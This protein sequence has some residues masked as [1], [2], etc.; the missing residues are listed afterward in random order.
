MPRRRHLPPGEKHRKSFERISIIYNALDGMQQGD[1]VTCASLAETLGVDI[2]TVL[3]DIDT[4]RSD[5]GMPIEYNQC[6][7]SYY[8]NHSREFEVPV[9]QV[10][11]RERIVLIVAEMMVGQAQGTPLSRSLKSLFHKIRIRHEDSSALDR[12]RIKRL[13]SFHGQPVR[14]VSE[15]VWTRLLEA[16]RKPRVVTMEYQG[17]EDKESCTRAVEPLHV[18]CVEGDWYLL[19]YDRDKSGIRYFALSRIKSLLRTSTKARK[20]R[21]NP[22]TALSNRFG[23]S[24]GLPGKTTTV[25]LEFAPEVTDEIKERKWHAEQQLEIQPGRPA[26]LSM[27]VPTDALYHSVKRWI[28]G[29]GAMVKVLEPSELRTTILNEYRAALRR[30]EEPAVHP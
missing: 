14:L 27:P 22:K 9:V 4:M 16:M 18:A 29:W 19:A 28:L 5:M 26:V 24:I 23:Q 21:F 17:L 3:R 10:A 30:H 6:E 11:N 12:R 8:Y 15:Q 2:R 20:H 1:R 25:V 7:K 13:V